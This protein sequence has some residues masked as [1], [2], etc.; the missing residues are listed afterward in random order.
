MQLE[1]LAYGAHALVMFFLMDQRVPT[2]SEKLSNYGSSLRTNEEEVFVGISTAHK[3]AD[4]SDV[5]ALHFTR[6]SYT[7]FVQQ[8]KHCEQLQ[9]ATVPEFR[10]RGA[11]LPSCVH[12]RK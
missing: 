2:H 9:L 8:S 6:M 4:S 11:P 5:K 10:R 12:T 3:I 1:N 7:K